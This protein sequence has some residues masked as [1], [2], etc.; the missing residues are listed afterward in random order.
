MP[1]VRLP[2]HEA[3]LKIIYGGKIEMINLTIGTNTER[4]S[5][6]VEPDAVVGQVL[7]DNNVNT[8]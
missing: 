5:V 1:R 8:A 4:T 6:I 3:V 7:A 2:L